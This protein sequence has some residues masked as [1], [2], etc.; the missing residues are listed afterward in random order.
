MGD[1][2]QRRHLLSGL[3]VGAVHD[4]EDAAT[5]R[6]GRGARLLH[7]ERQPLLAG[8][9]V[10]REEAQH[11]LAEAL[12]GDPLTGGGDGGE[13]GHGRAGRDDQ[14]VRHP[15]GLLVGLGTEFAYDT[16]GEQQVQQTEHGDE[17]DGGD[18]K[19]HG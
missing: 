12:A 14:A 15:V 8:P 19:G 3:L 6:A 18:Q 11:G 9:A 4:G 2:G 1:L 17:D 10:G 7:E 13:A 5:G 16:E